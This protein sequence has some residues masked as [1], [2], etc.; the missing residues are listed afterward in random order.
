M[1][2]SASSYGS[3]SCQQIGRFVRRGHAGRR[4]SAFS[5]SVPVSANGLWPFYTYA[6]RGEDFVLGWVAFQDNQLGGF[7]IGRNQHFLEQR[8]LPPGDPLLSRRVHQYALNW[9][10]PPTPFRAR[11]SSGL[12][13]TDPAV[14][15]SGGGL[16]QTLT[17]PVAY[18][19]KVAYAG[20]NLTLSI[21]A[22]AGSFTGRLENP[23]SGH[24]HKIERRGVAKSG[25]RFRIFPRHE[26]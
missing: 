26:R 8:R 1:R 6:A 10:P 3:L 4:L 14:I 12:S 20:S 23:E 25:Q 18:D 19:G 17:N 7:T 11:K 15:L 24:V 21:N 2:P 22:A 9:P 5:Q 13:L 16:L